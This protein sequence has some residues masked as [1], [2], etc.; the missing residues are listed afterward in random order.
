MAEGGGEF[1][2]EDKAL[3]KKIDKNDNWNL[4]WDDDQHDINTTQ[5]F[6]PTTSSTPYHGGEKHEMQTMQYEQSGLPSYN[7]TTRLL[8]TTEEIERRLAALRENPRT[9]IINT[10]Q[11]M[12]T[13]I[14]PLSEEERA[15]QIK[16]VKRLIKAEYPNAKVDILVISVSKKKPMDIVV[17]GPK[18]GETKIVLNDGSGLQ[19]D[20]LNKTFVKKVLGPTAREIIDQ[21][22]IHI[23]NS[24][25]R[26]RYLGRHATL[27][28]TNGCLNP[29][30]I[31]FPLFRVHVKITEC[32]NHALP[33]VS[34]ETNH[35]TVVC[36]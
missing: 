27:L 11:M 10:T 24:L 9:G 36:Q 15:E 31:C 13:S 3:D 12:D 22:D 32:T 8:T 20:F 33:I 6:E 7:E 21:A 25:L 2:Y 1:G 29:N 34:A 18:G 16:K 19:K 14:N 28:P 26:S 30:P 5:F 35:V 17:L 23:R 4:E